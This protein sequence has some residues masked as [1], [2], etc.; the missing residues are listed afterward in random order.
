MNE[1]EKEVARCLSET[2]S[3]GRHGHS[4]DTD[5]RARN[6]LARIAPGE[7]VAWRVVFPKEIR[8]SLEMGDIVQLVDGPTS[9]GEIYGPPW[10]LHPLYLAPPP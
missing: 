1:R 4:V 7:P 2:Y 6:L 10:E 8:A 9:P 5:M 3:D